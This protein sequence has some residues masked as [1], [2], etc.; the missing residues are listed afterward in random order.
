MT[1]QH[2]FPIHAC[3]FSPSWDSAIRLFAMYHNELLKPESLLS[4]TKLGDSD[5]YVLI[6]L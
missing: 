2:T 1:P 5:L 4:S 6:F 3:E